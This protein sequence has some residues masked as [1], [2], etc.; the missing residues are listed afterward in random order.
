MISR[1]K[2]LS[3]ITVGAFIPSVVKA[4]G[5]GGSAVKVKESDANAQALK[6]VEV[7]EV[8]G[9]NCANCVLY[10]PSDEEGWG[11]CSALQNNLVAKEGWC[12]AWAKG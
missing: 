11:A 12:I 2:L 3:F 1:R 5:H 8:E 10:R 7:S 4:A 9:Q 6:Y